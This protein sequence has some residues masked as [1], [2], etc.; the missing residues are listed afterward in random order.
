VAGVGAATVAA[1][2]HGI[3]AP[4]AHVDALHISNIPWMY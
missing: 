2:A 3:P 1:S 4:A